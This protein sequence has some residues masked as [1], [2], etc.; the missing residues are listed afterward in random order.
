MRD[1][2]SHFIDNLYQTWQE[3]I[4][5]WTCCRVDTTRCAISYQFYCKV[6]A[7]SPWKCRSRSTVVVCNTQPRTSDYL[8]QMWKESIHNK[9]YRADTRAHHGRTYG[10]TDRQAGIQYTPLPLPPT[11]TNIKTATFNDPSLLLNEIYIAFIN[12]WLSNSCLRG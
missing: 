9:L 2:P 11:H 5:H 12:D 7:Q 8:C 6:R 1:L 3:S 10:P 4:Q